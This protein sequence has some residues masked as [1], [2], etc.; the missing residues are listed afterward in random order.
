M[1]RSKKKILWESLF[2]GAQMLLVALV[3]THE[4]GLRY[5]DLTIPINYVGDTV[6]HLMIAKAI[7]KEGWWWHIRSLSAPFGANF[8]AFP[9]AGNLDYATMKLLSVFA[10]QPGLLVNTY[11]LATIVIAAPIASWSILRFGVDR[12]AAFVLGI[13]YA[14]SPHIYYRNVAHLML[15]H[16]LIP[17][18]VSLA[19]LLASGCVGQ[20]RAWTRRFLLAGVF[21]IGFS[22]VYYA[23]FSCFVLGVGGAV[24]F[25]RTRRPEVLK[26]AAVAILILLSAATANLLPSLRSWSVDP[27]SRRMVEFKAP[28]EADIYGLKIRQL[29]MPTSGNPIHFL[30]GF[31]AK[32]DAARFPFENEN[33]FARM[34]SVASVG[35]IALVLFSL[36]SWSGTRKGIK[37]EYWAGLSAVNLACVLLGTVGGFGSFFNLLVAPDIRCYNRISIFI[38]FLSV[39]AAGLIITKCCSFVGNSNWRRVLKGGALVLVL[40]F[41]IVDQNEAGALIGRKSEDETK[42]QVQS[43]F[44]R[45]IEAQ[46]P[47]DSAI[48]QMPDIPLTSGGVYK[49]ISTSHAEAF[50]VSN[51]LR[52]SWPAISSEAVGLAERLQLHD[53]IDLVDELS[54]LDFKGIY[55]DRLGYEDNGDKVVRALT[56]YL[57]KEPLESADKRYEFFSLVEIAGRT[58]AEQTLAYRSRVH[59]D[60]SYQLGVPVSFDKSVAE[61]AS[62]YLGGGWEAEAP[63]SAGVRC[64][65]GKIATMFFDL[66]SGATDITI[67]TQLDPVLFADIKVRPVH[68]FVNDVYVGDWEVSK[69]DWYSVLVPAEIVRKKPRLYLRF[70][71]PNAVS[72]N[73]LGVNSDGRVLSVAFRQIILSRAENN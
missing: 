2:Y 4:L 19:V 31:Q 57:M 10:R 3:L 20:E 58:Q 40:L 65:D 72:P 12:W 69:P 66:A 42:F 67:K 47:S 64:T 24:G 5:R 14:L 49:T 43:S 61:N 11:W 45:Q 48:Y 54:K 59:T 30:A 15:T 7:I 25:Y 63:S 33:A 28:A 36:F 6:Y 18:V 68:V 29:I 32:V 55:I 23:F 60:S 26:T 27:G 71:L 53:T 38:A 34:G 39:V 44:V 52:W 50:V 73:S 1:L 16:H 56:E 22:Y 70:E 8:V 35:F 13:L 62:K 21:L 41:G 9:V 46:V 51:S 37:A 17:L